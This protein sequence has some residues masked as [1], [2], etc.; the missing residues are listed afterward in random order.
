MRPEEI[1]WHGAALA[2]R[3][4]DHV[5]T[6]ERLGVMLRAHRRRR[7][8]ALALATAM[9]VA[10]VVGAF[11]L[12]RIGEPP[13]ITVPTTPPMTPPSTVDGLAPLPVEV[14]MVLEGAYTVDG[15]TGTCEGSGPL[16]GIEEG[17]SVEVRDESTT[18][19]ATAITLPAGVEITEADPR[20]SFLLSRDE[21]AVCVFVLPDLGY[22]IAD[23][24][25]ISL[26]PASDPNVG[27]SMSLRGQRVIFGFG[28]SP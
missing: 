2:E 16:A 10:V 19:E 15:D 12:T 7:I 9:V 21:V 5:D 1:R 20:S 28:D 6:Q 13:V 23:Y 22:D 25:N 17:S 3:V 8:A 26:F 11:M 4:R 14:F 27:S 18:G 24:D